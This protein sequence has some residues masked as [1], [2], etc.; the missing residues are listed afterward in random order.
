MKK[1]IVIGSGGAGKSTLA[2]KLG[3]VLNINI[4]HLDTLMWKPNWEMI[5]HNEQ[6]KI[7]EEIIKNDEWIIDGNYGKTLDIRLNAADTI[8]FLD[9]PRIVCIYRVFKRYLKYRNR[10]RPDMVEG[11]KEKI[12]LDFLKWIWK[13]PKVNKPIIIN[14]IKRISVEKKVII[15]KSNKDIKRLI[16]RKTSINHNI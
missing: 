10:T 8:I 12:D 2:S 16:E 13:Y 3:N 1:I 7:Q 6:I 11:N 4:Y 14:K 9:F 5:S 15:I